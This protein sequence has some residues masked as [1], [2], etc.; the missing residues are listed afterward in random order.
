MPTPFLHDLAALDPDLG[1]AVLASSTGG[2]EEIT[3]RGGEALVR[4]G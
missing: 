4:E 1:A 3:I 2:F